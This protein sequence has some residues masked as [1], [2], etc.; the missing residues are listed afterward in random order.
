MMHPVAGEVPSSAGILPS[1][2]RRDGSP[3]PRPSEKRTL[4]RALD[5]IGEGSSESADRLLTA[6]VCAF[7]RSA[8]LWL[9][10]GIARIERGR[11]EHARAA[12]KMAAWLEDDPEARALLDA[13]G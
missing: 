12:L 1:A 7:P 9:A 10:A 8:D 6:A 3:G 5:L 13:L 11:I 4:A 2:P